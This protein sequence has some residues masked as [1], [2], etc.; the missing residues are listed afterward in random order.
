M[1]LSFKK[2]AKCLKELHSPEQQESN[3]HRL[4][5]KAVLAHEH[6]LSL[7]TERA[8]SRDT[9]QEKHAVTR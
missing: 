9:R 2:P 7:E 6:A 8:T 3:T 1:R 4:F 5:I